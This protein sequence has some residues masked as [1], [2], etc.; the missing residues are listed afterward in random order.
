MTEVDPLT[1]DRARREIGATINSNNNHRIELILH[2]KCP[3]LTRTYAIKLIITND[4]R[5]LVYYPSI[6]SPWYLRCI[7]KPLIFIQTLSFGYKMPNW[8]TNSGKLIFTWH[9]R[10]SFFM[11]AYIR[12]SVALMHKYL[13][14]KCDVRQWDRSAWKKRKK[15][16][17][18][19]DV[20]HL[21]MTVRIEKPGR[22]G[23]PAYHWRE[24]V[25]VL[26]QGPVTGWF[27]WLH[28]YMKLTAR[29]AGQ[30]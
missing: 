22:F 24:S 7:E 17:R 14:I 8:F 3:P 16:L 6:T 10:M 25:T 18:W 29:L 4:F 9:S 2:K 21:G 19:V 1:W 23:M 5:S 20:L 12:S 30:K 11:G 26:I 28:T 27:R 13:T 15:A